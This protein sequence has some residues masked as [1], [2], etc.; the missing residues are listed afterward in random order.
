MSNNPSKPSD[1][2]RQQN[3]TLLQ[4]VAANS[5]MGKSALQQ[6]TPLTQDAA[7]KAELLREQNIYRQI[8]QEAHT[9]IAA[10]GEQTKG[11]GVVA[12]LGSK[13]GIAMKTM[14]QPDTRTLAEMVA[15]G[16]QQGVIDC[17]ENLRDCPQATP[18]A[19]R[20]AQRLQDHNQDFAQ[21]MQNFL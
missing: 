21:Q 7:L 10:C 2:K 8:N 17:I 11:Q 14:G 15:E 1:C 20:L 5:E 16:A 3:L 13:M 9:A 4:A 6:I 19:K 18:G 12:K